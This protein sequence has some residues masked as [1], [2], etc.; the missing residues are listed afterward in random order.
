MCVLVSVVIDVCACVFLCQS[1]YVF[2]S[3]FVCLRMC[4][5]VCVFICLCASGTGPTLRVA[6]LYVGRGA[7]EGHRD[8]LEAGVKG[9]RP[10]VG[11]GVFVVRGEKVNLRGLHRFLHPLQN[12]QSRKKQRMQHSQNR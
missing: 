12:L 5:C 6:Y 4:V 11:L 2:V 9:Q 1:V 7:T 8:L 10:C 3:V